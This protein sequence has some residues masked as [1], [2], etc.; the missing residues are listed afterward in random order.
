MSAID[1]I[2][3]T[4]FPR[5]AKGNS[6]Q[7]Y[8]TRHLSQQRLEDIVLAL[9]NLF[10]SANQLLLKNFHQVEQPRAVLGDG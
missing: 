5:F 3:L 10:K 4:S 6:P 8:L 2:C 1:L 9:K 7:S